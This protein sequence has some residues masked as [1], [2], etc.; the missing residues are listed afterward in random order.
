MNTNKYNLK[1]LEEAKEF[2]PY[3]LSSEISQAS[4][5]QTCQCSSSPCHNCGNCGIA[6]IGSLN[7]YKKSK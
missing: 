3:E 6:K 7:L 1:L 2:T 4:N 5:C